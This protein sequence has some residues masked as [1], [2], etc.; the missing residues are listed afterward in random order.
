M[1]SFRIPLAQI[2]IAGC[3]ASLCATTTSSTISG[4]TGYRPP[5]DADRAWFAAHAVKAVSA[6]V[7]EL[8]L[9]RINAYRAANGL[10]EINLRPQAMGRE[11][12]TSAMIAAGTA[13]APPPP[14]ALPDAVDNSALPFFPP[15]SSQG[16]LNCCAAFSTTYY[17]F[18]TMANEAN[19]TPVNGDE[20]RYSPKWTFDMVNRGGNN[21]TNFTDVY[22]ILLKHGCASWADMPYNDNCTQWSTDPDVWEN[23]MS[24]RADQVGTL[25]L[26]RSS[27]EL[28]TLK[29]FINNGYVIAFS[30]SI[31]AW[32]YLPLSNDPSTDKDDAFS[33]QEG[34]AWTKGGCDHAMTIVG[35]NDMVWIDINQ[36]GAVDAGEKGALKIANSWDVSYSN[37]GF[38][39][40]SYD[41]LTKET[42]VPNYVNTLKDNLIIETAWITVKPNYSPR[43]IARFTLNT[44][45][46]DQMSVKL[47]Y[48]S[49]SETTPSA[50][51]TPEALDYKG[52]P[53]AFDGGTTAVDGTFSLDFTDLINDNGL[54]VATRKR[55]YLIVSDSAADGKSVSVKDFSLF[56]VDANQTIAS[57]NSFPQSADGSSATVW[58]D[59]PSTPGFVVHSSASTGATLS[60]TANQDFVSGATDTIDVSTDSGFT[61]TDVLVDGNSIGATNQIVIANITANHEVSVVASHTADKSFVPIRGVEYACYEGAWNEIPSFADLSTVKTGTEDSLDISVRTRDD[62]FGI[63]YTGYIFAPTAGQYTFTL[64]SDDGS[65]F[66]IGKTLVVDNNGLHGIDITTGTGTVSLNS[67]YHAFRLPYFDNAADQGLRLAMRAPGSASHIVG[68][69]DLVRYGG[70]VAVSPHAALRTAHP[71]FI[72]RGSSLRFSG[73]PNKT[74]DLV[75]STASGRMVLTRSATPARG[76]AEVTLP[77]LAPGWYLCS[78]KASGTALFKKQLMIV[79]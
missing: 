51:W 38:T 39:W 63:V 26:L 76:A 18:T 31:G 43:L 60:A 17:Q 47:G 33:G 42:Q 20:N 66:Y 48:S 49:T 4:A 25:G 57:T 22:K 79:R 64:N 36:N 34:V 77:S 9:S 59:Y 54:S 44:P 10:A 32:Q 50:T 2:V 58:V 14:A 55:W 30:T 27:A 15:I 16:G 8:G 40:I 24:V 73:L 21:G 5:T 3:A 52:G 74:V 62:Q 13:A 71:D 35:Y 45:L 29:E 72:L 56:D 68:A 37:K 12:I 67:G 75:L 41:A 19:N 11:V 7:T 53:L 23:A 46:R 61:V 70:V 1:R 6:G 69:A 65:A 78:V 28:T